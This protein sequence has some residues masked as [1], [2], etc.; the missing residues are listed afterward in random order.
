MIQILDTSKKQKAMVLIGASWYARYFKNGKEFR[1]ALGAADE[2]LAIRRRNKFFRELVQ[3]GATIKPRRTPQEKLLDKPDLYI[4][5]RPPYQFK[6]KGKVLLE[7][8]DEKEVREARDTWL[9][10]N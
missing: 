3:Q 8:W 2:K 1:K 5:S 10:E 9:L 4:Y 7:S 6:V